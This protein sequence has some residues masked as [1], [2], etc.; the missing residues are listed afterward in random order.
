[1]PEINELFR[2]V[3]NNPIYYKDGKVSSAIFLDSKGVSV[4]IDDGRELEEIVLAEEGLHEFYN[5]EA[6]LSE[7][8]EK[9]KLIA[10]TSVTK[11][12]CDEKNVFVELEPIE[13]ENPYH[14]IIKRTPEIIELTGSQRKYLAKHA[15]VV[16]SY[17][18]D[19]IRETE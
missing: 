3:R 13:G 9:Y 2:R 1:M 4:D 15:R 6:L 5:K 8:A 16:K 17:N 7:H 14:A 10:I 12:S 19:L 18:T 11:E